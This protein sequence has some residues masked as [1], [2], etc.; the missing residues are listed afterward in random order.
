MFILAGDN[1]G[2]PLLSPIAVISRANFYGLFGIK[3][4]RKIL[5]RLPAHFGNCSEVAEPLKRGSRFVHRD[6]GA[7]QQ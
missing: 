2:N 1:H 5:V 6:A 4:T 7:D 3:H